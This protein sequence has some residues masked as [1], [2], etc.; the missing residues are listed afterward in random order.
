MVATWHTLIFGDNS[1]YYVYGKCWITAWTSD[2]PDASSESATGVQV[3][4]RQLCDWVEPPLLEPPF[5][6][7]LPIGKDL[8]LEITSLG[9][10]SWKHMG[11]RFFSI[12]NHILFSYIICG[13]WSDW[14][15]LI[16]VHTNVYL[17]IIHYIISINKRWWLMKYST[18]SFGRLKHNV[19]IN[20][21]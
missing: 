19:H 3:K 5:K 4:A 20:V 1:K 10:F 11:E 16:C 15:V 14:C 8:F 7:W 18:H 17:L 6:G 9:V 13:Y 21:K 12:S 2:S